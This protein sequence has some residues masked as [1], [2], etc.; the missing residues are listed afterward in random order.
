MGC[1]RVRDGGKEIGFALDLELGEFGKIDHFGVVVL[2]EAG[3]DQ[4]GPIVFTARKG[5][6]DVGSF[7]AA[8]NSFKDMTGGTVERTLTYQPPFTKRN[9]NQDYAMVWAVLDKLKND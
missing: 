9:R 2:D 6:P 7:R 3:H 1:D 4:N 8:L 5:L